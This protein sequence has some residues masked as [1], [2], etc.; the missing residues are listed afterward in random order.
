MSTQKLQTISSDNVF[1]VDLPDLSTAEAAPLEL[2]GEYWSPEKEGETKRMYFNEV[3]MES[4]I[5]AQGQ[6]IELPVAYFVEIR[7]GRKVV[8]RQAGRR[9]VAVFETFKVPAGTPVEIVYLGKKK[10]KTNPYMSDH[11][12]VRPLSIQ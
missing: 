2:T 9:L 1:A 4:T 12:S 10:N 5:D 3:R 6:D 11:W 8:V 7:D